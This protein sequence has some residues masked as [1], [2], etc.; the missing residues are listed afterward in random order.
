M[1]ERID[2]ETI[3][4]TALLYSYL[5]YDPKEFAKRFDGWDLKELFERELLPSDFFTFRPPLHGWVIDGT[6]APEISLKM[7]GCV[8]AARPGGKQQVD[9]LR[10]KLEL[11]KAQEKY[12]KPFMPVFA[13]VRDDYPYHW[14]NGFLC[15]E[16]LDRPVAEL[17]EEAKNYVGNREPDLASMKMLAVFAKISPEE[18]QQRL[19]V[20][21]EIFLS[22]L[23]G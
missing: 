3:D 19:P 21:E 1:V 14:T 20:W 2:I 18:Q 11:A 4:E 17:I 23:R 8:I 12:G 22:P 5:L 16:D 9:T 13:Q 15:L 6:L 10:A 7:G